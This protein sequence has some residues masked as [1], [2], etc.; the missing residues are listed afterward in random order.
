MSLKSAYQWHQAWTAGGVAAVASQ[1][2]SGR[3]CKLS[4]R[5][6]E[7]PAGYLDPGPAVHG[8]DEE[9][10]WTG[11]RVATLTGRKFYVSYSVSLDGFLAGTGLSPDLSPP[12]P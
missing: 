2:A 1:G 6:Q 7:K 8:W 9:Q 11:A 3:R 5:C 10:V 4:A 12:S